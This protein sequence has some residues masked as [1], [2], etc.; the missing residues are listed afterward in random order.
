[1]GGPP[2]FR[3]GF[4]APPPRPFTFP[5]PAIGRLACAPPPLSS[6]SNSTLSGFLKRQLFPKPHVDLH[7]L[8]FLHLCRL[9]AP[10]APSFSSFIFKKR[11]LPPRR[12]AEF[13][14]ATRTPPP[15]CRL[16]ST[17]LRPYPVID[18]H[19]GFWEDPLTPSGQPDVSPLIFFAAVS[20]NGE[21]W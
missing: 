21:L 4:S 3:V 18:L 13:P 1:M 9:L 19:E 17:C 20:Q 10:I 11:V 14:R 8:T 2:E 15:S 16:F 5:S 6:F 7:D 12:M